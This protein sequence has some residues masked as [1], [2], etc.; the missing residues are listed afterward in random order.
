LQAELS[1]QNATVAGLQTRQNALIA[2][3]FSK[4]IVAQRACS[5]NTKIVTTSDDMLQQTI[6]TE[7]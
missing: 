7:R 5:G 1:R 3:E 4:L 2:R 6:D